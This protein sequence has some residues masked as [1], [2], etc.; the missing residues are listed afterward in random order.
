MT[1]QAHLL[2]D[3]QMQDFIT[4][5]YIQIQTDFSEPLHDRIYQKLEEVF[6]KEGNPGNNILPRVPEISQVFNHPALTGA[7][8]S[9]LGPDYN[10]NPHRHCH[11]NPPGS[12]GQSWHKDCYVF[13][14]NL[15]HPRFHWL[16]ALYYP[17]EVT[18]DMGPT[19]VLNGMHVCEK[20][21]NPNPQQCSEEELPLNGRAG[22]VNLVHFDAWHRA[23]ANTSTNKRYMLKFQFARLAEPTTPTWQHNSTDWL[24][25]ESPDSLALDVWHWLLG[26]KAPQTQTPHNGDPNQLRQDLHHTSEIHRRRAAFSLASLAEDHIALLLEDLD[27]EA[28]E[29]EQGIEDKTPD[30]AHGTNPTAFA[31]AQALVAMGPKAVPHVAAALN[32]DHWLTRAALVDVLGTIGAPAADTVPLLIERLAD[33]HWWVRRNAAEALGRMHHAAADAADPLGQ[34]AGD[35][36]RRV[37]RMAALAL[38]QINQAS[39]TALPH[40]QKMLEDEDRYN[41]FYA[42]LALRRQ[43]QSAAQE[44]LLDSLFN[45]RWCPLTTNENMF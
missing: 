25:D 22:T 2:N 20:I 17:Q 38:A 30:N 24:A 40:L 23:L 8:T 41:R 35:T 32:A 16:L 9:L 3:R 21:S 36:D 4:Q 10:L 6:E 45:A 7:L 26:D 29:R 18:T 11:L 39:T 34:A 43:P 31:A 12:K 28:Y 44:L 37:R 14:H 42:G 15:R 27:R 5:G 33:D 1:D 13:D 19:G